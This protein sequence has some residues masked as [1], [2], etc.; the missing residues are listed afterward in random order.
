MTELV[1]SIY[2]PLQVQMTFQK[3]R[4]H[5]YLFP[6]Q[7]WCPFLELFSPFGACLSYPYIPASVLIP[8]ALFQVTLTWEKK[9]HRTG[10]KD[11][12]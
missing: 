7:A 12:F 6:N 8:A 11:F 3:K 10:L 4:P 5:P 2:G 9:I 1:G